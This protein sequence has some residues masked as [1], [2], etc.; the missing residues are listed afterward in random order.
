M[1][2]HSGGTEWARLVLAVPGRAEGNLRAQMS[3]YPGAQQPLHRHQSPEG[4]V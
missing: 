3:L 1:V 2:Q 4:C